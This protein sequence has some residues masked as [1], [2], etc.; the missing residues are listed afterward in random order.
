VQDVEIQFDFGVEFLGRL[1]LSVDHVGAREDGIFK[2]LGVLG[3]T[4][5]DLLL[6][7]FASGFLHG[8]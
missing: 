8:E 6:R 5:G 1:H 4:L 7:S 3:K 2:G